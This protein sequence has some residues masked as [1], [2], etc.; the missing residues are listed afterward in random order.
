MIPFLRRRIAYAAVGVAMVGLGV[1]GCYF[2]RVPRPQPSP[3]FGVASLLEGMKQV[4][5][6]KSTDPAVLLAEEEADFHAQYI[7]LPPDA[8]A[9]K[10][11]NLYDR[12]MAL[13]PKSDAWNDVQYVKSMRSGFINWVPAPA[14]WPAMEKL[15]EARPADLEADRKSE[16][17]L[18]F[19]IHTLNNEE[20]KQWQDLDAI[21]QLEAAP[22]P[23]PNSPQNSQSLDVWLPLGEKLCQV[24]TDG[25]KV[26][27]FWDK[28]IARFEPA[29][30]PPPAPTLPEAGIAV[31]A[32]PPAPFRSY[33]RPASVTLDLPD[34]VS[35]V[36]ADQA[37]SLLQRALVLPNVLVEVPRGTATQ[38]LAR[39]LAL[40][41][42]DKI[43]QPPW[44]L[45]DS[46]EGTA[47]F[48]A[49][50]ARFGRPG[51]MCTGTLFEKY[52]LIEQGQFDRAALV[53]VSTAPG[54][55]PNEVEQVALA[56][57]Y[58]GNH[59]DQLYDYYRSRVMLGQN[60][61]TNFLDVAG[62]LGRMGEALKTIEEVHDKAAL[63]A[64]A[65]NLALVYRYQA[66][67]ANDQIDEGLAALTSCRDLPAISPQPGDYPYYWLIETRLDMSLAAA[68]VCLLTGRDAEFDKNMFQMVDLFKAAAGTK[69]NLTTQELD[70]LSSTIELLVDKNHLRD[71]ELLL[72]MLIEVEV[73]RNREKLDQG[74]SDEILKSEILLL[75]TFYYEGQDWD[76]VLALLRDFPYWNESDLAGLPYDQ[77]RLGSRT[78]Y[79]LQ[80]IAARS[81]AKKGRLDEA[82]PLL[83]EVLQMFPANDQAY[84]LLLDIDDNPIPKLDALYAEDR[85]EKRPLIWKAV[86]L[87]K[88]GK[89]DD[90]EKVCRKAI[91]IDPSDGMEGKLDRM[92]AYGVLAEILRANGKPDEAA[93]MQSICDAIRMSEQADDF[94]N[95]WLF[96]RATKLY[97][98]ALGTFSDAYCIESRLAKR[99]T[100]LG[101]ID[102]AA[103][104]YRR[105]FELMPSS[106]GRM[107]SHCFGCEGIFEGRVAQD[108]AEQVFTGL[109]A[110]EPDKAQV[111]YLLGLLRLEQGRNHEAVELFKEATKL[112]PDYINAWIKLLELDR[113]EGL[114]P[115]LCDAAVLA[116]IRLDPQFRHGFPDFSHVRDLAQVWTAK[117]AADKLQVPRW[118]SRLFSLEASHAVLEKKLRRAVQGTMV[119]P[120]FELRLTGAMSPLTDPKPDPDVV[121]SRNDLIETLRQRWRESLQ[122]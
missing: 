122:N 82:R 49:L 113:T 1:W 6:P 92:R 51:G 111:P 35:L 95:A 62:K 80:L 5:A 64:S 90:A 58:T 109:T 40:G 104:H 55:N 67:L 87:M 86:V 50:A 78:A 77:C 105:A 76:D 116:R 19:L 98:Q 91:A 117:A 96:T 54:L 57:L 61:W 112:D 108:T 107:E 101:K 110:K 70:D 115:S 53:P 24:A 16:A 18:R 74:E 23:A 94:Y 81:L 37:T 21:G 56:H 45:T 33:N 48:E 39:D 29:P 63:P 25:K 52:A 26:A 89:Y 42:V 9:T 121:L 102:E 79:P 88:Q 118:S 93:K 31:P 7:N 65:R 17:M 20:E 75:I 85:F 43:Q 28:A 36:G 73:A 41:L 100:D 15:I 32:V 72:H 3:F 38:K 2:F 59:G 44:D 120:N 30:A 46:S 12:A 4:V 22:N 83:D 114:P 119:T 11:M 66:L 27:D 60:E 69:E 84:S 13:K 47:L 103:T 34:F 106:F 99:L 8:I 71:A 10:W 97:E 68:R 14:A